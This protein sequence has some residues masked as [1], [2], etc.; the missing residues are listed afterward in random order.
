[1][2]A[3]QWVKEN[4]FDFSNFLRRYKRCT[5][6][7]GVPGLPSSEAWSAHLVFVCTYAAGLRMAGGSGVTVQVNASRACKYDVEAPSRIEAVGKRAEPPIAQAATFAGLFR[8]GGRCGHADRT[9]I[10][11]FNC[12]S[13]CHADMPL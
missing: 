9:T 12:H 6:T 5:V 13:V 8:L 10:Q 11:I 4:E 2:T 3:T 7:S 1:M